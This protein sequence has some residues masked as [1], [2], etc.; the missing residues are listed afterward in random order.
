M[1]IKVSKP[2]VRSTLSNYHPRKGSK[3]VSKEKQT[4]YIRE[5]KECQTRIKKQKDQEEKEDRLWKVFEREREI[6]YKL[7]KA[8]EEREYNEQRRKEKRF[9]GM[10]AK[11][12]GRIEREREIS[13]R[14]S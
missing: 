10:V 11:E 13:K 9:E 12:L 5:W 7:K 8:A 2:S 3:S 4:S 6:R 1:Q 14:K